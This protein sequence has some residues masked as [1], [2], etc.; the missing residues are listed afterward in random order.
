MKSCD[1]VRDREFLGR[2]FKTTQSRKCKNILLYNEYDI[3][4]IKCRSMDP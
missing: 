2:T 3:S 4:A 1:T